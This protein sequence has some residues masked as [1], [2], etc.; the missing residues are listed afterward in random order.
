MKSDRQNSDVG[1]DSIEFETDVQMSL[2]GLPELE[3]GQ[4]HVKYVDETKGQRRK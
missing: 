4:N 2:L 3:L 1:I